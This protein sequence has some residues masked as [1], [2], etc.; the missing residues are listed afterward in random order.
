MLTGCKF[1]ANPT[2]EQ[3]CVLSQWMGCARFIWNAKCEENRYLCSFARRYLPLDTFP[4]I[5]QTYSQ[6][7]TELSPWLFQVPSQ[8]LR[9]SASNWYQTYKMFIRGICGRPRRKKKSDVGSVLLTRE[10]FSFEVC[11]DGVLRLFIG[12]KKNNIGYLS[13]T[14]HCKYKTPNSLRITRKNGTYWVSFCYDDHINEESLLTQA[15]HLE[16]LKGCSSEELEKMTIGIDRGVKIPVQ[17]GK[18]EFDFTEQQQKKKRT[19]EREIKRSQRRMA[20]QKKGSKRWKRSKRKIAKAHETIGNIRKDFCHKTSRTIVNQQEIKVVVLEALSTK[21]MTAKKKA[22]QDPIT[23]KW[24][25]NGQTVKAQLNRSILDKGWSLLELFLRYK[26]HR[27]GKAL[28][29]IE[30]HYTSQ[31]CAGCGHTHPSNRKTQALFCCGSCGHSDNAD[32]NAAEVIKKRAIN[33]I[34]NSG[35]ELSSK[36]ILQDIGR[37]AASKTRKARAIRASSNEASKKK[38]LVA[39]AI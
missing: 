16:Y 4:S 8:I 3:K 24:E 33:L 14:I 2:S 7:K 6:Y 32:H 10:L 39:Q 13:M 21:T 29:K 12:T 5:D 26:L 37:G 27:A 36:G 22:A 30:A 38:E 18:T 34:L 9:N 23:Q 28:F 25:K 31:E 17:A 11:A 35:T 20:A 1:K 15:E 19:K